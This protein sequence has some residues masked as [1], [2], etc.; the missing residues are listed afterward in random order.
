MLA[1]RAYEGETEFRLEDIEVP[2]AGPGEVV[3]E[4]AAAGLAPSLLTFWRMG[5]LPLLPHT[6]GHE[7]AGV[8]AAVGAGV[9]EHAA[10]DR[11]R[12]HPNLTC[13]RCASC[14][15]DRDQLCPA[16]SMIGHGIFGPTGMPLYERYHD[17]A[18]AEYVLAPAWAVDAL[19]DSVSF[20]AAAKIHDVAVALRALKLAAPSPG[21]TVVWTAAT[22]AIGP[23]AVR[24]APLFGIRR[25]I[26]VGRS[27]ERLDEVR[28]LAPDL[29]EVVALDRLDTDWETEQGLTRAIRELAP[30]GVDVVLDFLPEGK[31]TQQSIAALKVGGTAVIVGGNFDA[32]ATARELVGNCWRILGSRNGSRDDARQVMAWL[33]SGALTIDDLFTHRFALADV[34]AAVDLLQTRATPA[35]MTAVHPKR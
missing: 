28:A 25:F 8:V 1:A 17:G 6:P 34:G 20:E 27:G 29:V 33:A 35:W 15:T 13:R 2:T 19:P 32:P 18:L 14:L 21:A 7:A 3:I 31:G 30:A 16:C 4:V 26:A 5:L 23:A 22:G 24:L 12:M 10:G 11:V 9:T